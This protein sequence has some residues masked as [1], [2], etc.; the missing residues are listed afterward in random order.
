LLQD[1]LRK[2]FAPQLYVTLTRSNAK[3]IIW[4][5]LLRLNEHYD[6]G[7]KPNL[8]DLTLTWDTGAAIHLR[9]ANNEREIAKIRGKRFKRAVI[10]EAQAFP[11]RILRPLVDDTIGPALLDFDGELWVVGTPGPIPVGYFHD[12]DVGKHSEGWDHHS[13]TM[14]EN[15]WLPRLSGR[16]IDDLIEE[17]LKDHGWTSSSPTF[18]R[19]YLGEWT[20]DKD[21]LVFHWS[22]AINA[23]QKKPEGAWTYVMGVDLG[24]VDSDAVAVLGWTDNDPAVYLVD[25]VVQSKLTVSECGKMVKELWERWRPVA[26]EV[27]AGGLGKKILEELQR[28]G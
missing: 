7:G 26:T 16:K 20:L 4:G 10:D 17:V 18:R 1:A 9:G 24:F 12:I 8:V 22:D 15:I 21:A 13:W 6:L 19:E 14:R 5:D 2:P 11:D 25:E 28:R 23:Y 27:D 3:E